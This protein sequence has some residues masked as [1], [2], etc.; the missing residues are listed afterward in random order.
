MPTRIILIEGHAALR[1]GLE[2]L[3]RQKGCDVAGAGGTIA[4]ARAL[5]D[6]HAP[7]VALIDVHLGSES[8]IALT[9]EM[10]REQSRCRVVLYTGSSDPDLL[11]EGL[12]AG[13]TGYALKD[14][15]PDELLA[16]IEAAATGR[17]YIDPRLRDGMPPVRAS[18]ER[19][20]ILSKRER[21]VIDHLAQG[22]TGEQVAELLFLSA[23]TVKTHVRNAMG[24][25]DAST[26]VHAVALA[27]REGEIAGPPAAYAAVRSPK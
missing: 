23:E 12:D 7:D 2:L 6:A 20:P 14:G 11:V 21:E 18:V 10:L 13:A 3:L 4:E 16:A 27:L 5:L 8:G 26:R 17:L 22:L 25:L 15:E 1:K 24:K 19:T 9:R